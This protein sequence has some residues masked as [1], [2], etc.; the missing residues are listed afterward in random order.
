[1]R[2]LGGAIATLSFNRERLQRSLRVGHLCATDVADQL[3]TLG[4]PFREAHHTVGQLVRRAE[5]LGVQIDELP[6][7]E[8]QA[9][10]PGLTPE[11][12]SAVFSV[13]AAVER[14]ALVGG[15]ARAR[16]IE[17]IADARVRWSASSR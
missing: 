5:E 8:I 11:R 2:A 15:P 9:V 14:R 13:E 10:H 7:Q 12:I 17:A 3:V 16:V 4:V 1:M 6:M